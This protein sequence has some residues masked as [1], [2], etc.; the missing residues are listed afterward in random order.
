MSKSTKTLM[1][2]LAVAYLAVGLVL[3]VWPEQ[4][5][6]ILCYVVGAAALAYGLFRIIWYF[7][8]KGDPNALHFGVAI[9][10]ASLVLGAFLLFRANAVVAVLAAA[11][12]VAVIV[13]SIL[14]LQIALDLKRVGVHNWAGVLVSALALLV[15]GGV[16]LFNPFTAVKAAT[17]V[18]GVAL[19]I[20]G[21]LT[22]WSLIE[23]ERR[24]TARTTVVK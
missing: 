12:G 22:I 20:D 14:R 8:R 18:A 6:L 10:I 7:A 17:I 5:R 9:G 24:S 1:W 15:M 21:A 2:V 13:G 11:I 19:M 16:L 4:S 23:W 3:T